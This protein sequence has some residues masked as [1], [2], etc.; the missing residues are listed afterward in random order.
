MHLSNLESRYVYFNTY[1][2]FYRCNICL[3]CYSSCDILSM[4][5]EARGL[6]HSKQSRCYFAKSR[7]LFTLSSEVFNIN[8]YKKK[9]TTTYG[10]LVCLG[11]KFLGCY[12]N[13]PAALQV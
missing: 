4:K 5:A 9:D 1:I 6:K 13:C 8:W 3:K 2:Y 10:S 7:S 12:G 11:R